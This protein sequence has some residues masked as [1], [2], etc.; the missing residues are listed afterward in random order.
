MYSSLGTDKNHTE[1]KGVSGKGSPCVGSLSHL[2]SEP[3]SPGFDS[4]SRKKSR[5]RGGRI[6]ESEI[7]SNSHEVTTEGW[8]TLKM[9]QQRA[10]G[11]RTESCLGFVKLEA[12]V[13]PCVKGT[14]G[15]HNCRK[16]TCSSSVRL[17]YIHPCVAARVLTKA[18][19][20]A[21]G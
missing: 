4:F 2:T 17:K 7:H 18:E 12:E 8:D 1:P 10:K 6:V 21:T 3:C 15:L 16:H 20:T 14:R 9:C 5:N 19:E 11:K 13:V